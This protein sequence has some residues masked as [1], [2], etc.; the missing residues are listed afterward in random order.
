MACFA[1]VSVLFGFHARKRF[2]SA[3][4]ILHKIPS[5]ESSAECPSLFR[6]AALPKRSRLACVLR[7]LPPS[8]CESLLATDP[9]VDSFGQRV[10]AHA[11]PGTFTSIVLANG[12]PRLVIRPIA[13]GFTRLILTRH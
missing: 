8:S 11:G 2:L 7:P 13:I 4:G 1:L 5:L 10:V 6:L 12:L 3:V 9:L